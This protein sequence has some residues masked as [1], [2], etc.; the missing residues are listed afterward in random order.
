MND[1]S[2]GQATIRERLPT[3]RM[4][5]IALL[6]SVAGVAGS[7]A[8]AGFT[9]SFIVGPIAGAMARQLPAQVITFAIL[10]LGDVGDQLNIVTAL[11]ISMLLLAAASLAGLLL[12]DRFDAPPVGILVGAAGGIAIAFVV[13]AA[14]LASVVTG[15]A[16]GVV[17]AVGELSV[18]GG[19]VGG[20]SEERRS[21]LGGV[22]SAIGLS[23]GG[24]VLG[25][26]GGV[27]GSSGSVALDVEPSVASEI[28]SLLSEA[29]AKS[30]NVPGLEPL[31]S[32]SFYEVDINA[33]DPNL[34]TADWELSVTGAVDESVSYSYEDVRE[35]GAEN[36]FVS[37]RCV[38][39]SLNGKKLDNALWTGIPIMDVVDPAG[40]AEECCVMLRAADGFYEEFPLSALSDGFLAYGMNGDVLPRGH[41]YPVRALIPGHW[42]E[43]NVKWITE[44]EVLEEEVDGYWE[45]RGWH[46][47]G[48][49]ETVAKLHL[50]DHLDDGR[51]RVGGHAFAGTRGI[52]QVELS[53]DGGE[54]WTDVTRSEPLPGAD[55]RR[56][57]SHVYD[58]PGS[59]HEV[60][61][62]ATDGTGT[63]QPEDE[64]DAFP[65]GPTG[66]VSKIVQP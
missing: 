16:M 60:V 42:G 20:I 53:T 58:S 33:T 55:V 47:T 51:I 57:W 2:S 6:A 12:G 44:I 63:L 31:V 27:T 65:S 4:V 9:P 23:I 17:I 43:I 40:P 21:V 10:V 48:P 61:V 59:E 56:Q 54:S 24:F 1:P 28:D 37:L 49:V 14:P 7:Y 46:G 22:A 8:I 25:S 26:R 62:R 29:D 52:D 30:L 34:D 15:V 11:G 64:T 19:E 39:E 13:T 32:E 45:E 41:G 50:I 3:P 35:M 66:W 38:G 36:R 5:A 18:R